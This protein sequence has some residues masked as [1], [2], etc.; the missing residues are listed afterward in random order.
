MANLNEAIIRKD[1][2]KSLNESE[3]PQKNKCPEGVKEWTFAD[4]F[5]R[6]LSGETYDGDIDCSWHQFTSLK[7]AP[8]IVNGN[9]DCSH[10]RLASLKG[11]PEIVNGDF[12]CYNCGL[13]SFEWCPTI[14][15]G[16][17]NCAA[18]RIASFDYSPKEIGGD[19]ICHS[20]SFTSLEGA[21]E[22]IGGKFVHYLKNLNDE[23]SY[24]KEYEK[25][26]KTVKSV[27]KNSFFAFNIG[28]DAINKCKDMF[29]GKIKDITIDKKQMK[30]VIPS[31]K[32][33]NFYESVIAIESVI[34]NGQQINCNEIVCCKNGKYTPFPIDVKSISITL[35]D[36]NKKTIV[37]ATT[38]QK[39]GILDINGMIDNDKYD[40]F[41][42]DG[43]IARR[44]MKEFGTYNKN[45]DIHEWFDNHSKYNI[46]ISD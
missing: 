3:E 19:F 5:G 29:D 15:K 22:K 24:A 17:F 9:F 20:N 42:D 34:K 37:K 4:W 27:I 13:T 14:I 11:A 7:G 16:S 39:I 46:E 1:L 32:L 40:S 2:E 18:N 30:I 45:L 26:E 28:N 33:K 31:S 21:P 6:D 23:K 35:A 8:K 43:K 10:N 38:N 25:F 44:A 12:S 36:G 41:Y